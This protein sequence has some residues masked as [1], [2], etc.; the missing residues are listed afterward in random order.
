MGSIGNLDLNISETYKKQSLLPLV[1]LKLDLSPEFTV[2]F[3]TIVT[4]EACLTQDQT[5]GV[6][7]TYLNSVTAVVTYLQPHFFEL[8]KKI[9]LST[10][11][12]PLSRPR[13]TPTS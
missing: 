5:L 2:T 4:I 9:N 7:S 11:F 6:Y 3:V 1:R 13:V 8:P 12:Y 10:N